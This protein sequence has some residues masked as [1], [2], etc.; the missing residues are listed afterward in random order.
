M[1]LLLSEGQEAQDPV[2]ALGEREPPVGEPRSPRCGAERSARSPLDERDGLW[3]RRERTSRSGT[4]ASSSSS[5]SGMLLH[6]PPLIKRVMRGFWVV[7]T[8]IRIAYSGCPA[9]WRYGLSEATAG[10]SFNSFNSLGSTT[11]DIFG[12]LSPSG[13]FS[14]SFKSRWPAADSSPRGRR[15]SSQKAEAQKEEK[16]TDGRPRGRQG[17]SIMECG[18]FFLHDE[19]C[20]STVIYARKRPRIHH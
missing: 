15:F 10:V 13:V 6:R 12:T 1:G 18:S 7:L 19:Q 17:P 11:S 16:K 4:P 8:A 2:V 20:R 9:R 3:N 14:P 5:H